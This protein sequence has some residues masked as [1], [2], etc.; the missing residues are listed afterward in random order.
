M[1]TKERKA[2]VKKKSAERD[3]VS[4]EIVELSKKRQA[5]IQKE[6]KKAGKGKNSLDATIFKSISKQ[7]GKKGLKFEDGPSL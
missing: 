4:K 6:L 7:A 3:K 1:D 2:Y 5:F